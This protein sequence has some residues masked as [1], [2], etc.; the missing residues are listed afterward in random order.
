MSKCT[1]RKSLVLEVQNRAGS[2]FDL[3]V[4][5]DVKPASLLVEIKTGFSFDDFAFG[6]ILFTPGETAT[7]PVHETEMRWVKKQYLLHSG[8]F[9]Q[10]FALNSIGYRYYLSGGVR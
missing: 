1:V 2:G 8:R 9:M 5:T 3:Y 7:L 10:P 4:R 6:G